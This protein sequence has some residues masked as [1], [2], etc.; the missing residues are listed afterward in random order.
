M[1]PDYLKNL[2]FEC[3]DCYTLT[4]IEST[5]VLFINDK[6]AGVYYSWNTYLP[7]ELQKHVFTRVYNEIKLV[8]EDIELLLS[9]G[10]QRFYNLF[11]QGLLKGSY[12]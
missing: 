1:T 11:Q 8:K 6:K 10:V 2:C 5:D 9:V 12:I 4:F 3:G 7:N